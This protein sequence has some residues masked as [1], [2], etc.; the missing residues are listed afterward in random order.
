MNS[1]EHVRL[2][3]AAAM[4]LGLEKGR[5]YRDAKLGCIN[6]LMIY[7]DGCRGNCAFCGQGRDMPEN[8]DCRSLIRVDWPTYPME[9]VIDRLVH[10]EKNTPHV[11]RICISAVTHRNSSRDMLDMVKR[12][13]Q[14]VNLPISA[15]ITPTN[16]KKDDMQELKDAGVQRIGI[17]V[18]AATE[19]LFE[20]H[21][22]KAVK[23]PHS[24][25]GYM[26]GLRNA[27]DVMGAEETGV[28]LIVGLGETEH[29]AIS[30]MQD[31]VDMG[32]EIHLFSFY[33]EPDSRL[34]DHPQPPMDTY[35]TVQIAHAMIH[36]GTSSYSKMVFDESGNLTDFGVSRET[37][38]Q[39]VRDGR[40]FITS[41]CSG[42]NRPFANETPE[43]AMEGK[44]RNY[45]F[46][47]QPDDI[48]IISGQVRQ[49]KQAATP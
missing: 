9:T 10:A 15:L 5:F 13:R 47:P 11:E 29:Q 49:L 41:G 24:W 18:D 27:I 31:V 21:R 38:E 46:L 26:E 45:P 14:R 4:T 23:G 48:E 43:Q 22:G 33:P 34:Q 28:H 2:S 6:L 44:F 32:S 40:A 35:R 17:A 42:C 3:L 16:F 1:P 25:T 37:L 20:Q 19:D 36:D 39:V 8:A 30:F 7:D 12:I